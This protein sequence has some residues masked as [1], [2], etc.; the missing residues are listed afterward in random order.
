MLGLH[1][2]SVNFQKILLIGCGRPRD[3]ALPVCTFKKQSQK[4]VSAQFTSEQILPLQAHN[5]LQPVVWGRLGGRG[6]HT[7]PSVTPPRLT[8]APAIM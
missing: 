6:I 5:V 7:M 8:V 4:A 2:S 3:N 1:L